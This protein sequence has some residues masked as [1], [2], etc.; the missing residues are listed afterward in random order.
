MGISGD[1]NEVV[2]IPSAKQKRLQLVKLANGF[3]EEEL[4]DDQKSIQPKS[5]LVEEMEQE[6]NEYRESQFR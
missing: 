1:P 5:K 2:S 4:A 3:V 6:A